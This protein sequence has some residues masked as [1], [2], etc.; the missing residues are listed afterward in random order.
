MPSYYSTWRA[1]L[2][3]CNIIGNKTFLNLHVKCP[4]FLPDFNQILFSQHNFHKSLQFKISRKSVQWEPRW[5]MRTDR[6]SLC[7]IASETWSQSHSVKFWNKSSLSRPKG[8]QQKTFIC[9]VASVLTKT[10]TATATAAFRQNLQGPWRKDP[11]R[12]EGETF[13]PNNME[14]YTKRHRA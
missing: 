7:H 2:W 1:P 10:P 4:T 14:S 13:V 12:N 6:R 8:L 9:G 3:L 5:K 11:E